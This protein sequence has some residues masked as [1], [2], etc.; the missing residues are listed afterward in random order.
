MIARH[1][2][3]VAVVINAAADAAQRAG[4]SDRCSA[5]PSFDGHGQADDA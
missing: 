2:A 3:V 5:G 1:L 4:R